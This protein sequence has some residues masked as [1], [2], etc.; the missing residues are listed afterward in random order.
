MTM[1]DL[2]KW[3]MVA[4]ESGGGGGKARISWQPKK[5]KESQICL[6]VWTTK[7][8]GLLR[9]Q[10]HKKTHNNHGE[11]FPFFARESQ[12]CQFVELFLFAV[13][14]T[15][16]FLSFFSLLSFC[17]RHLALSS[18]YPSCPQALTK[19][20]EGEEDPPLL[21]PFYLFF[22]LPCYPRK[23]RKEEEGSLSQDGWTH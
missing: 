12:C 8:R 17:K 9:V 1:M 19:G 11:S 3:L 23:R 15:F 10:V 7:N 4:K 16:S 13:M 14:A 22:F 2:P 18:N 20:K 21:P 5:G 6:S